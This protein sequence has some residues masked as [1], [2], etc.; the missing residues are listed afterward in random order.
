VSSAA[1]AT[2]VSWQCGHF[3]RFPANS[4]FSESFRP[5]CG[6]AIT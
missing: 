5:H 2:K 6:H 4:G 1:G 3:I